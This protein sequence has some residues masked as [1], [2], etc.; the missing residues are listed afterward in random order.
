MGR[1][2]EEGTARFPEHAVTATCELGARRGP[3]VSGSPENPPTP[4]SLVGGP[5]P[6]RCWAA[7]GSR[8]PACSDPADEARRR[9]DMSL[10]ERSC[11]TAHSADTQDPAGLFLI[12]PR[13]ARWVWGRGGQASGSRWCETLGLRHK[14]PHSGTEDD[15][16]APSP[17]SPGSQGP[18]SR[19]RRPH[20]LGTR[21]E[22][23]SCFH[24]NVWPRRTPGPLAPRPPPP[25]PVSLRPRQTSS[26]KDGHSIKARPGPL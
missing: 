21:G 25:P 23:A 24:L 18:E 12:P 4:H 20:S 7:L 16:N 5:G 9:E 10:T 22:G 6:R 15:R 8:R 17:P 14:A 19:C 1:G 2:A 11:S 26:S 13:P 3:G